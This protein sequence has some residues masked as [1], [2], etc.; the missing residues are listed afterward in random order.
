MAKQAFGYIYMTTNLVNGKKYIG[1][2]ASPVFVKSYKGSGT[3]IC[4]AFKKYGLENFETKVLEWCSNQEELDKSERRFIEQYD[5][6]NSE[7]FYNLASGGSFGNARKGSKMSEEGKAKIAKATAGENNPMYGK[8]HTK[9]SC[10]MMAK[11]HADFKGENSPSYK[12]ICINNGN[13]VKYVNSEELS[14]YLSK[15]WRLGITEE[16]SKKK[17]EESKGR[18]HSKETRE[19]LSFANKGEK[20]GMFGKKMSEETKKLF[21]KQRTGRKWINNGTD[22]KFVKPEDIEMYLQQ[23]WMLGRTSPTDETKKKTSASCKGKQT[24]HKEEVIKKVNEDEL[25]KYILEGWIIGLP[26][27][28]GKMISERKSGKKQSP[29]CIVK[30]SITF[31]GRIWVN[32]GIENK[33]IIPSDLESYLEKGYTKGKLKEKLVS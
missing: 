9:E 1:Q 20:N 10:E 31:K 17:S 6:V 16:M 24:I 33:W 29:E 4:K 25:D 21:S 3:L 8:H 15:G 2:K 23:G 22:N 32:N 12:R 27:S 14:D 28:F 19:K 30:R 13:K 26:D 7:D 18:H 5:A 11:H